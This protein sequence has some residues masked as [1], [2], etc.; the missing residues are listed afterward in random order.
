MC[1]QTAMRI[2]VE[3][4]QTLIAPGE[5]C[6]MGS[7]ASKL[8]SGLLMAVLARRSRVPSWAQHCQATKLR[9]PAPDYGKR[10]SACHRSYATH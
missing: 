1:T 3:L 5:L 6:L 4:P 10:I 7:Q 8:L 2:T 9:L